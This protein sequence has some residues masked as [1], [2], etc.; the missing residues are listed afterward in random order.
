VPT[1]AISIFTGFIYGLFKAKNT[2]SCKKG[3]KAFIGSVENNTTAI[4]KHYEN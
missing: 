3:L 1:I 4:A 2:S